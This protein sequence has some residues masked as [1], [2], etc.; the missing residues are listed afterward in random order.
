M[1]EKINR[2]DRVRVHIYNHH[3]QLLGS[4][5]GTVSEVAPDKEVAPGVR[6]NLICV[7]GLEDYR[8]QDASGQLKQVAE[9]WF[10]DTVVEKI[11][12]ASGKPVQRLFLN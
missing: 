7:T 9:D 8:R 5:E 2:G 3:G 12:D 10:A 1:A 11:A 6:K 4:I